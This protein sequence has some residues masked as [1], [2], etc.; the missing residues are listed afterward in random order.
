[1][2]TL[3]FAGLRVDDSKSVIVKSSNLVWEERTEVPKNEQ[4]DTI[5]NFLASKII[6][7]YTFFPTTTNLSTATDVICS[8]N[9]MSSVTFSRGW[10]NFSS[11]LRGSPIKLE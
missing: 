11:S 9:T 3:N 1:M 10:V 4:K 7:F 2:F 6:Q 5:D 8:P